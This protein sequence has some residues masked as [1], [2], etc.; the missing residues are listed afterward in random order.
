MS[1][2]INKLCANGNAF[3][4]AKQQLPSIIDKGNG[5]FRVLGVA[6]SF[7]IYTVEFTAGLVSCDCEGARWERACYH[8]AAAFEIHQ[9]NLAAQA[10]ETQPQTTPAQ[11]VEALR[12]AQRA[13]QD[14]A[15]YLKRSNKPAEFVSG[16]RI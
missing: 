11:E 8:A 6:G 3:D 4:K 2:S 7:E 16:I 10:A 13:E 14:A 1:I 12:R 15:P 5:T 9:A